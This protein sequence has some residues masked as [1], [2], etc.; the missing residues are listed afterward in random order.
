VADQPPCGRPQ[1]FTLIELLITLTVIGI[2]ATVAYPAY[3]EHV[4]RAR[5]SEAFHALSAVVQAQERWRAGHARYAQSLESLGLPAYSSPGQHYQ[6]ELQNDDTRG[7]S[8]FIAV[9]RPSGAQRADGRCAQ[10]RMGIQ[11][12]L[13]L[14]TASDS[15]GVDTSH[16]CW[17]G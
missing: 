7:H 8:H 12:N 2:L 10:L 3:R 11:G 17:P 15:Q 1:G 5:R 14:R 4:L 13:L 9:A 6:I 16:L